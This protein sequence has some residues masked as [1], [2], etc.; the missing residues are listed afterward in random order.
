MA[1]RPVSSARLRGSDGAAGVRRVMKSVCAA[2]P[3]A[4]V[5]A[6]D[7][8]LA[9]AAVEAGRAEHCS[10]QYVVFSET[11]ATL[12]A[13]RRASATGLHPLAGLLVAQVMPSPTNLSHPLVAEYQRALLMQGEGVKATQAS[14]PSIEGYQAMRVLIEALRLCHRDPS[15][16]CLQQ[17]LLSRSLDLPGLRVQFGAA[18]RQPH[19]FVEMTLLDAWGRLQR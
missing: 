12:L 10:A 18:Q 16:R 19:P 2:E 3:Q 4:V 8:A 1:M 15:G 9:A 7:G 5:L 17:M 11:G 13:T 14:Y 6:L